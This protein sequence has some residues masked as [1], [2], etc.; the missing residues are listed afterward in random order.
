[1]Q[2]HKP[3]AT[4]TISGPTPK[5][6]RV[7]ALF[8]HLPRFV[9]HLLAVQLP[10]MQPPYA[11]DSHSPTSLLC[12]G[13][14]VQPSSGTIQSSKP[15][16]APVSHAAWRQPQPRATSSTP[17]HDPLHASTCRWSGAMHRTSHTHTHCRCSHSPWAL[18]QV[19]GP[20]HPQRLLYLLGVGVGHMPAL[21]HHIG[22]RSQLPQQQLVAAWLGRGGLHLTPGA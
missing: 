11:V 16:T 9:Q 17:P 13:K 22:C 2:S 15:R 5:T 6:K 7:A 21:C 12:C 8:A 3:L 1:M 20:Q 10:C 14:H 4:A 19:H 18:P